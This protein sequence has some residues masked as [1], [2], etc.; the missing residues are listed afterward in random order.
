MK[1]NLKVESFETDIEVDASAV[2]NIAVSEWFKRGGDAAFL[3]THD[4]DENS[5]VIDVGAYTG[6]WSEKIN[7]KYRPNLIILEPVS[8]FR[9]LL[10][11]KFKSQSN[12]KI[13]PHGLGSPGKFKINLSGDGSSLFQS[14]G[15]GDYEEIR[16]VSFD[17]FVKDNEI[18]AID[19]M[20]INIEGSEYDLLKQILESDLLRRIK[21]IQVQ[22]HTNVP[23]AAQ[24]R[25]HIRQELS[26][27][28]REI[29]NFPFVWEAWVLNSASS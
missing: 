2:F 5:L 18:K 27:T 28:H 22:F 20:Q 19:L 3:E 1:C 24:K 29:L 26:K 25:Q 9:N 13:V 7:S 16:V 23:D 21:K 17:E 12:I 4:I 6:V 10:V 11:D 15:S 14:S 8:K